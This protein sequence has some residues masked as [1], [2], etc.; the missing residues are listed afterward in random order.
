MSSSHLQRGLGS[1][2]IVE[3]L[4]SLESELKQA[5]EQM[6][7]LLAVKEA[8]HSV[9]EERKHHHHDDDPPPPDVQSLS[10][11]D[12]K[13]VFADDATTP[14]PTRTSSVAFLSGTPVVA[15]AAVASQY[16]ATSPTPV[17]KPST[18]T[19][20]AS[21][22]L[23]SRGRKDHPTTATHRI[24]LTAG[25]SSKYSHNQHDSLLSCHRRSS[26]L[27]LSSSTSTTS[28]SSA[29]STASGSM[30]RSMRRVDLA[31]F[32]SPRRFQTSLNRNTYSDSKLTWVPSQET[33]KA[34]ARKR[35]DRF[36]STEEIMI[37]R[38]VNQVF[39]K[40]AD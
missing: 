28:S 11:I 35:S 5:L 8:D 33:V 19:T 4:D 21:T 36:H 29:V 31:I 3:K 26:S 38:K 15:A 30:S 22:I 27:S 1:A 39:Y 10:P 40:V 37:A 16:I 14:A 23:S 7:A 2:E 9:K 32:K 12:S 25:S 20:S 6:K 18:M 34:H 24:V 17:L 13:P